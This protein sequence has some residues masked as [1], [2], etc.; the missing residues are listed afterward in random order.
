M[1]LQAK[2]IS[3]VSQ[4]VLFSRVVTGLHVSRV[5]VRTDKLLTK[6]FLKPNP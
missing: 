2:L 4:T 1:Q 5:R 3:R 6:T